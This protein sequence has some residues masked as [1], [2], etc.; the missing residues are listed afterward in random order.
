MRQKIQKLLDEKV[1]P[2][3]A[4]HGGKINVVDYANRT[5]Y[6]TMTG[7]CQGCAS[8]KATLQGGVEQAIF[9]AFPKVREILDV[10]DHE[11]GINPYY[12]Q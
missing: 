2:S 5:V 6:I 1:N 3:V 9:N 4:A 12:L 7:G 10:T 11:A 8:S